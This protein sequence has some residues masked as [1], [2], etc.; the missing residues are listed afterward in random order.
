MYAPMLSP[1]N[2]PIDTPDYFSTLTFPLLGSPKY[3]GIRGLVRNATVL[4]RTLKPLP[5]TQ[6]QD[7]FHKAENA[8]GETII[9]APTDFGVYNRTQSHVMSKKKPADVAGYFV[10]DYA[11]IGDNLLLPFYKR[12]ETARDLVEMLNDPCIHFV[13]H[14]VIENLEQ[15]FLFENKCLRLGYEGIM[16]RNPEGIYM[17]G[18]LENRCTLNQNII[19]KLKRFTDTEGMLLD[20]EEGETNNNVQER[21]ERGLA[22]RSDHK[23]NK[24]ASGM[25]GRYIVLFEGKPIK[26]TPGS[27]SH[28]ERKEHLLNKEEHLGR[29]LKFRY[30]AHGIKDLPRVARALGFRDKRDM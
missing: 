4:S 16:L 19:R 25:A 1:N 15:L 29:Y 2:S 5:S 6:I 9:G 24:T 18:K 14:E 7:M 12:L 8:D 11:E 21:D 20:I 22:K 26:V 27:F 23:A 3:D 13:E 30:F 17:H 10:F 28:A